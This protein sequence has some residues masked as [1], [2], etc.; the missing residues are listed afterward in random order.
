MFLNKS[1]FNKFLTIAAMSLAAYVSTAQTWVNLEPHLVKSQGMNPLFSDGVAQG[2]PVDTSEVLAAQLPEVSMIRKAGVGNDVILRGFA[3]DNLNVLIDGQRIYGACPNRMDPPISHVSAC[4]VEDIQ[5]KRAGLDVT[6]SGSLGGLLQVSTR[7]PSAMQALDLEATMG[8]FGFRQM[9][10]VATAGN[11][12]V[13]FLFSGNYQETRAYEDGRGDR[14]TDMP[15]DTSNARDDYID[16]HRSDLVASIRREKIKM[17]YTPED[18]RAWTFTFSHEDGKDIFYPALKMDSDLNEGFYGGLLY[19]HS[20]PCSAYDAMTLNMYANRIDHEMRDR[21]R[22]SSVVNAAN[23]AWSIA[24]AA[25]AA[26]GW[27]MESVAQTSAFGMHW[28]ARKAMDQYHIQ[29]GGEWYRRNWDVDNTVMTI[30]NSMIPEVD[31]DVAGVF[32]EVERPVDAWLFTVGGRLDHA[33]YGVGDTPTTLNARLGNPDL[34]K[35][36]V[37]WSGS[38]VARYMWEDQS[39]AYVSVGRSVR[40]PNQQERYMNL[41]RGGTTQNWLGNPALEPTF[42]YELSLGG[43]T[44]FCQVQLRAKLFHSWLDGFIY[45]DTLPAQGT[46]TGTNKSARSYRNIDARLYGGDVS[47]LYALNEH[48]TL[49]SALAWQRGE[50]DEFPNSN[51][52]KDLAE[53]PPLTARLAASGRYDRYG[54]RAEV[55]AADRQSRIDTDVGE[56]PLG[57]YAVFNLGADLALDDTF[58]LSVGIDNVL[59]KHYAIHNAYTRDPFGADAIIYEPG[60]FVFA[61]LKAAF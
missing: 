56:Q 12:R 5:V 61:T 37:A 21:Y 55:L 44:E 28:Q 39:H 34:S 35:D 50:K 33:R 46:G 11:E 27:S 6:R 29:Y 22:R 13:Q 15:D 36:A 19:E 42:N 23:V 49:E 47:A 51:M 2:M 7:D 41:L 9:A 26:R 38:A 52:D 48:W 1:L 20:V 25:I 3:Q 43:Q 4:D 16:S 31:M 45:A 53:I 57:G 60:R 32:V 8:S 30:N 24:N 17:R 14:I 54:M 58:S 10:A 40:F 59:D 18:A